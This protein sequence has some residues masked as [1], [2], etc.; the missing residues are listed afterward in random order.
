MAEGRIAFVG[1]RPELTILEGILD[2]CQ[3]LDSPGIVQ[4]A[5]EP[6]IGK[7]RLVAELCARA[8]GRQYLVLAG[9][10]AEFERDLPFG[11]FV[12]ALDDYLASLDPKWFGGL[13]A[14][15]LSELATAFPALT[16]LAGDQTPGLQDERYRTYRA[17]R[18]LLAELADPQPVVIILDDLH[19]ADPASV[20]LITYLLAHNPQG[21]VVVVV[22]FRPA[23]IPPQLARALADAVREGRSVRLELSPLS[24]AE[25][26]ELTGDTLANNAASELYRESGGN[27]FYLEQLVRGLA[28][29]W[30]GVSSAPDFNDLSVPPMVR[31]AL[32]NEL[33][34]L[35]ALDRTLLEGA[36]VA[37]DPFEYSL[38]AVAAEMVESDALVIL[39][40]LVVRDLVHPTT[41]P[42]RFRF[43]HPIVRRT[44]YELARPGWRLGAHGRCA[45]ALAVQGGTTPTCAHHM[46]RSAQIGDEAAIA[47]LVEAAKSTSPR[48]PA[49]AAHWYEA[50][51]RL[52]PASRQND[53]RHL[54]LLL[55]FAT[56]LFTAGRL[57]ECHRTLLEVL[58]RLPSGREGRIGLVAYCAAVESLLGRHDDA[59]RRLLEALGG[60]DDHNSLEALML[61]VELSE[62]GL[63]RGSSSSYA[64]M[65]HW[66]E[67][68]HETSR[69]LHHRPLRAVS[70]ALVAYAE[71]VLGSPTGG[72]V[73]LSEAAGLFDDLKDAE[74]AQRLDAGYVLG[75]T[76]IL[77]EQF[78]DAIRHCR[79]AI[80]VSRAT[81][82]GQFVLGTILAEAWA[83][84]GAGR[85]GEALDLTTKAVEAARMAG[86]AQFLSLA[87]CE[88]CGVARQVGDLA[89]AIRAGEEAV[90]EANKFDPNVVT[91]WS[92]VLLGDALLE[93]GESQR[94]RSETLA[95]TGGPDLPLFPRYWRCQTYEVLT[96]AELSLGRL[97]AAQEWAARAEAEARK[98]L[99]AI[100]TGIASRARAAVMLAH[101]EALPAA[102]LALAAAESAAGAGARVEAGRSRTLAGRAYAQAGDR[103][104]G[105]VEVEQA[106]AELN[107]CGA[108]GYRDQSRAALRSLGHRPGRRAG[109]GQEVTGFD[110]LTA[111]E[112]EIAELVSTGKTNR[113]I[114]AACY[115]SEKTV[116]RHLSHLF[117]KLGVSNRAAVAGMV[118]R[119]RESSG[120]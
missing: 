9:R 15:G 47:M 40:H 62:E 4:V 113:E 39:D 90:R 50:A 72:R 101:G 120:R 115:L 37:G 33:A 7:T 105:I 51:L 36:A 52:L 24:P 45:T 81:G 57:G 65:R 2:A 70:A 119:R 66:A 25:A 79:R 13:G 95:A 14:Q 69:S 77:M 85:L 31:A 76:E 97:E 21:S 78:D 64:Q 109:I 55:A 43:R 56:S 23:Q 34:S 117:D 118:A 58:E 8:E 59:N 35:P 32:A 60:L 103:E 28:L 86:L 108:H 74:L 5:G 112:R 6:G 87:L 99:L 116:E 88:H 54:E 11:V 94:G 49:T 63:Y 1:R 110:S 42:R 67:G 91:A 75:W 48:A 17:V 114:A 84:A 93:A 53:S 96:R 27:P 89:T 41:V 102:E 22:V 68:A 104:R 83:L 30:S 20:E 61:K 16:P 10:A 29:S 80:A 26:S 73:R 92:G 71:Y 82:Q 3:G 107:A 18:A 98:G 106:E 12:D 111:R 100:E 38:A 19:W 44:V 46:E